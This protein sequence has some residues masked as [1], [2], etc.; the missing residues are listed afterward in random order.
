MNLGGNQCGSSLRHRCPTSGLDEGA[1]G[2]DV[3]VVL[4]S[5][6]IS[7]NVFPDSNGLQPF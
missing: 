7:S 3:R 2:D 4:V 6:I 1:V 5:T